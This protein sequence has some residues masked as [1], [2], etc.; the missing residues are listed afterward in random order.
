MGNG[1]AALPAAV[2]C[3]Q[4]TASAVGR[5]EYVGQ[6]VCSEPFAEPH[7]RTQREGTLGCPS[8]VAGPGQFRATLDDARIVAQR[9]EPVKAPASRTGWRVVC[10]RH[11]TQWRTVK[12]WGDEVVCVVDGADFDRAMLETTMVGLRPNE[13]VEAVSPSAALR[14]TK[15]G[16]GHAGAV[17]VLSCRDVL[18]RV[19]RRSRI[20]IL[21]LECAM[22][23]PRDRERYGGAEVGRGGNLID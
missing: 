6:F 8:Q 23:R 5:I 12:Y 3:W 11:L 9:R 1:H 13:L 18:P 21:S 4:R 20:I 15:F 2:A 17:T 19:R 10:A 16:D 22:R 7:P 14:G